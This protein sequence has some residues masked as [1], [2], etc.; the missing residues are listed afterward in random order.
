MKKIESSIA[1]TTSS[2]SLSVSHVETSFAGDRKVSPLVTQLPW[3][4]N[5]IILGQ[6]K[7]QEE[8]EFYI[9]MA[10]KERWGKCRTLGKLFVIAVCFRRGT[11]P[12]M[13][14]FQFWSSH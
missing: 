1:K 3:T 9:R 12:D 4:H 5:L 14:S 10:I 8:R 6:A 11:K 7:R 2:E 13:M